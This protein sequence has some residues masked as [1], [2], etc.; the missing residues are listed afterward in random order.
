MEIKY[1]RR[2]TTDRDYEF[3]EYEVTASI[4]QDD[5]AVAAMKQL[6]ADVEAAHNDEVQEDPPPPKKE[7]KPKKGKKEK[8]EDDS[9]DEDESDGDDESDDEESDDETEENDDEGNDDDAGDESDDSAEDD[10]EKKPTG[11]GK[12]K[13]GKKAGTAGSTTST[14]KNFRKK[15]QVYQRSNETH[16]ELFSSLM[17]SVAPKWKSSP[18]SKAKA[19]SVSKKMEGKEFLDED[20]KIFPAFKEQVRKSM[21]GKK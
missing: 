9:D 10:E 12:K 5:G 18:E 1:K 2:F 8:D 16:K 15:P 6:K 3:E 19:K 17:K 13:T 7:K 21:G 14:K 11:T 4:D 20:G